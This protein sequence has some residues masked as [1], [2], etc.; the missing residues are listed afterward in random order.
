MNLLDNPFWDLVDWVTRMSIEVEYAWNYD[1]NQKKT[2]YTG[3]SFEKWK[4]K[5]GHIHIKDMAN[6]HIKG[7]IEY[8]E[9]VPGAV[10]R[11]GGDTMAAGWIKAF[12]DELK[13]RGVSFTP[14]KKY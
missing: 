1:Y 5:D 12:E 3:N 8:I 9:K 6:G 10:S 4:T 7:S 2:K 13:S 11:L 14:S